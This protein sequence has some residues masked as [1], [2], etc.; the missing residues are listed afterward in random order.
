[1]AHLAG[2]V[3]DGTGFARRDQRF[4]RVGGKEIGGAQIEPHRGVIILW[5][6]LNSRTVPRQTSGIHHNVDVLR[7]KYLRQRREVAL[8]QHQ[9]LGT[10][11]RSRHG[12]DGVF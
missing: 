5:R 2:D 12:R 3:D 6:G 1:M 7:F 4:S 10:H 9:R 11:A 8:I